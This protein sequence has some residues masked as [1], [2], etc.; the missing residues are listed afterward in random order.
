MEL[1]QKTTTLSQPLMW[2]ILAGY[3]VREEFKNKK[4]L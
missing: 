1:I 4:Q 3:F 2:K